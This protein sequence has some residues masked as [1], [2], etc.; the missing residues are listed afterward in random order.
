MLESSLSSVGII[1]I[2]SCLPEK[3]LTNTDL[4]K[5]VDTNDEWIVKRTGISERRILAE[6]EPLYKLGI[7]AAKKA[8]TDAGIK[9]EDIGL[10]IVST[11]SPDYLTPSMACIIQKYTGAVNAAAFDMNAACSGFVYALTVAQQFIMTGHSKYVLVVACEGLSRIVDWNDRKTCILFGDGA[12]AAVLGPVEKDYGIIASDIGADGNVGHNITLP[13]FY[14][15]PED[16]EKRPGDVKNVIWMDGSEVFKFAVKVMAQTTERVIEKAGLSLDKIK[17]IVPHQANIRIIEG[18]SKRL[19]I[20]DDKVYSNVHKYG[21]ISSA[22]IPIALDEIVKS[23][24]I[25]KGDT[26]VLV[27]FGGGLTWASIVLKWSR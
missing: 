22:S 24:S 12:G 6:N 9:A 11:E 26:V 27:S 21:N 2:G 1:G 7:E 25:L 16:M 14:A 18:A 17:L 3:V 20:S 4:E 23:N 15:S 13:C 8:I 5:M 10:I 19:G